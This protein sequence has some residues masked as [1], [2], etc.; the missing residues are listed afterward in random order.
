MI[1]CLSRPPSLSI[2]TAAKKV[3][4][5]SRIRLVSGLSI[6]LHGVIALPDE[7][8]YGPRREKNCIRAFQLSE[9]QTSLLSYRD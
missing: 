8:S 5:I 7:T 2:Y 1:C 4:T 3:Y 9:I 6:L